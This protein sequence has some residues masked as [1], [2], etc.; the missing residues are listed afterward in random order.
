VRDDRR[1][2]SLKG[3]VGERAVAG[4]VDG[5]IDDKVG[6]VVAL[7]GVRDGEP[8]RQFILDV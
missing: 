5:P 1:Y 4:V 2:F 7:V 3:G 8:R 6:L